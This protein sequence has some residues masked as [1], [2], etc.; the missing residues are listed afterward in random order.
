MGCEDE[1]ACRQLFFNAF[2]EATFLRAGSVHSIMSLPMEEQDALWSNLLNLSQ[3][4][5]I[6][7]ML[8]TELERQGANFRAISA[9]LAERQ[10]AVLKIPVRVHMAGK[11]LLLPVEGGKHVG[12][13]LQELGREG[14]T[15]IVQGVPVGAE[16]E[17]GE[18]Y[19]LLGC[20]D[21][22]LHLCLL[23]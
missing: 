23:D 11:S 5:H 14:S 1:E 15:C 22:W 19:W 20:A 8:G 7:G 12:A 4:R 13:L 10:G 18:L 9:S 3:H 2:K 6:G 16:S 17:L 21:Q